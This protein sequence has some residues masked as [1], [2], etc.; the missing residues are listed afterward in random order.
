M[1]DVVGLRDGKVDEAVSKDEA[2]QAG[3]SPRANKKL[4]GGKHQDDEVEHHRI[5]EGGG[6]D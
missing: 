3:T 5:D 4:E 2:H 6:Q 1:K